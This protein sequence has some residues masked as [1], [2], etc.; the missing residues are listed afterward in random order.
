LRRPA[1]C[2]SLGNCLPDVD[3]NYCQDL[4]NLR[5]VQQVASRRY[6]RIIVNRRRAHD[7][8]YRIKNWIVQRWTFTEITPNSFHWTGESLMADGRTWKLGAEFRAGRVV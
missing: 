5:A 7:N 1:A 3:R 8:R 2:G 6:A 4:S